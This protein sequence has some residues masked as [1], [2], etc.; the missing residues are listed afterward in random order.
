M[1]VRRNFS[2]GW[3]TRHF[4]YP[5]HVADDAMQMHVHTTL[6]PFYTTTKMPPATAAIAKIA[7]RWRSNT[8]LSFTILFTLRSTKLRSLPLSAVP[9]S[10]HAKDVCVQQS[11]VVLLFMWLSQ[12]LLSSCYFRT[13]IKLCSL[14]R[15][16][17]FRR[18]CPM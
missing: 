1:G 6:C 17:K 8:S 7:F 4:A 18:F 2:R 14:I 16:I 12:D 11:H 5:F 15:V 9:V 13:L 3:Q 10:Q